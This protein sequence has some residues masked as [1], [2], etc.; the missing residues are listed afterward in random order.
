MTEQV[1]PI[2]IFYAFLPVFFY[3]SWLNIQKNHYLHINL[4]I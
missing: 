3:K 2:A 4:I 1:I